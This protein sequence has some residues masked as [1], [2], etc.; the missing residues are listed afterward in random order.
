M[1]YT[2]K[3]GY[4]E[5]ECPKCKGYFVRQY[6]IV[7]EGK[8]VAFRKSRDPKVEQDEEPKCPFCNYEFKLEDLPELV[9]VGEDG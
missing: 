3:F 9:E 8:L 7:E 4:I 6:A 1:I 5:I 2:T